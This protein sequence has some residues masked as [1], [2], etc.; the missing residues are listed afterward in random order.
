MKIRR[1]NKSKKTVAILILLFCGTFVT[2]FFMGLIS[3]GSSASIAITILGIL[4]LLYI[5]FKFSDNLSQEEIY[6]IEDI[7]ELTIVQKNTHH[8]RDSL[9]LF[10]YIGLAILWLGVK[11]ISEQYEIWVF[12]FVIFLI[13][14]I[15]NKFEGHDKWY[16]FLHF[17]PTQIIYRGEENEKN[18]IVMNISQIKQ[19]KLTKSSLLI[20]DRYGKLEIDTKDLSEKQISDL[21]AKVNEIAAIL[22]TTS[23]Y[24]NVAA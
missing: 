15:R 9:T 16:E 5:S 13:L 7:S 22:C 18:H 6:H 14:L 12:M 21:T 3:S 4:L 24:N 20:R 2:L 8:I 19:L 11:N 10:L 17:T 1:R 23:D